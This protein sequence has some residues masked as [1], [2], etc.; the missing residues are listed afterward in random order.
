MASGSEKIY[1]KTGTEYQTASILRNDSAIFRLHK[2]D[3]NLWQMIYQILAAYFEDNCADE[4]TND[5]FLTA[6]L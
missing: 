6:I 5:S 1:G 4:L 2:D 3:Q